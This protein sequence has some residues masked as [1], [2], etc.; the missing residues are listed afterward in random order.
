[1]DP[2][3]VISSLN[4]REKRGT[5]HRLAASGSFHAPS[6]HAGSESGVTN[7]K[8][9]KK[10]QNLR[11]KSFYVTYKREINS[12]LEKTCLPERGPRIVWP[13]VMRRGVDSFSPSSWDFPSVRN[14]GLSVQE[15][16]NTP[17]GDAR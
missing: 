6:F 13:R 2:Q 12:N 16:V 14:Q 9:S 5:P 4:I 11:V 8:K 17:E 10:M 3:H 1:L 7:S 15:K